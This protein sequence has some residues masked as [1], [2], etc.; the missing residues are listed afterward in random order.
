MTLEMPRLAQMGENSFHVSH[1][2]DA[3]LWVQ[4]SHEAVH[5]VAK[6]EME[7]RAIYK[8]VPFITIVFPA[9]K[10]KLVKRPVR[11]TEEES[12]GHPPDHIRF[13]RQWA[14]FKAAQEQGHDGTP[15]KEWAPLSGA[16]AME[17]NAMGI[18][19][20]EQLSG[21]PDSAA[22]N[23]GM[24]GRDLVNKA[25]AWLEQ[26]KDGTAVSRMSAQIAALEADNAGLKA[27]FAQIANERAI[28]KQA[29]QGQYGS[30]QQSGFMQSSMQ[31]VMQASQQNM[32]S[33]LDHAEPMKRGPGRPPKPRDEVA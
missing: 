26:A 11:M 30:H 25:K 31:E 17:L 2:D 10:T 27:Q 23:L 12:C 9:D 4:F 6:S 24:G 19:T 18:Y 8:D 1:G 16:R 22:A 20:V 13:P 14:A 21:V 15:I 3:K 7:G 5:Q 29:M 33:A 32:A 28:E